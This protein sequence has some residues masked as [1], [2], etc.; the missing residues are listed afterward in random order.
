MTS[1]SVLER[2]LEAPVLPLLQNCVFDV[3]KKLVFSAMLQQVC[4]IHSQQPF[5]S[6]DYTTHND[7]TDLHILLA[8]YTRPSRR[9]QLP[10]VNQLLVHW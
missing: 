8:H 2:I 3:T 5:K 10:H 9:R 6:T 7:D 1:N 4:D